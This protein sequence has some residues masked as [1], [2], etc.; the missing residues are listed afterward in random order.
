[1]EPGKYYVL[2]RDGKYL[3]FSTGADEWVIDPAQASS[4]VDQEVADYAAKC[5]SGPPGDLLIIRFSTNPNTAPWIR[6]PA[7]TLLPIDVRGPSRAVEASMMLLLTHLT[8]LHGRN[9]EVAVAGCTHRIM[10]ALDK[11]Y[12][13]VWDLESAVAYLRQDT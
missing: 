4:Y 3:N 2:R 11:Y 6:Q 7:L 9:Q 1:M 5:C 12:N 8:T 10:V 13:R